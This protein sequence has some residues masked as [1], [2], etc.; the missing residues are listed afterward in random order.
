MGLLCAGAVAL[1]LITV[2]Y[3]RSSNFVRLVKGSDGARIQKLRSLEKS[4]EKDEKRSLKS[5]SSNTRVT[6][7]GEASTRLKSAAQI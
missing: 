2:L 4:A 7:T 6:R 1:I 3:Y 5:K